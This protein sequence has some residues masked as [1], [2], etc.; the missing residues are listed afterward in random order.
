M[1]VNWSEVLGGIIIFLV[2]LMARGLGFGF[3][4][5]GEL[6]ALKTADEN[7]VKRITGLEDRVHEL[8]LTVNTM[9][10]VLAELK[11]YITGQAAKSPQ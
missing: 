1:N 3:S 4:V 8:T 10:T 11:G 9:A 2:G 6:A 5:K 7:T